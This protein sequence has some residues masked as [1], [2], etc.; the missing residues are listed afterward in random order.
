MISLLYTDPMQG[1]QG[2]AG[3]RPHG[4]RSVGGRAIHVALVSTT[5]LTMYMYNN[6][7]IIM[8]A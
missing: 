5:I 3:A 2:R 6:H 4:A 8:H 7:N 1:Q